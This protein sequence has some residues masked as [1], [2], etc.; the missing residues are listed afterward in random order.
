MNGTHDV[1]TIEQGAFIA[2]QV[3]DFTNNKIL[4]NRFLEEVSNS[5][6]FLGQN[7]VQDNLAL[8]QIIVKAGLYLLQ[9]GPSILQEHE[10]LF[11]G[12]LSAICTIIAG[13]PEILTLH[14]KPGAIAGEDELWSWL[15]N[16]LIN[17]LVTHEAENMSSSV[18]KAMYSVMNGLQL[19]NKNFD[20]VSDAI[21]FLLEIQEEFRLNRHV[22]KVT[23]KVECK[24]DDCHA[25]VQVRILLSIARFAALSD[26][27]ECLSLASRVRNEIAIRLIELTSRGSVP[28]L[29]TDSSV[30]F[31]LALTECTHVLGYGTLLTNWLPLVK[32]CFEALVEITQ[33]PD[34]NLTLLPN[35]TANG[36]EVAQRKALIMCLNDLASLLLQ[37]SERG[38]FYNKDNPRAVFSILLPIIDMLPASLQFKAVSLGWSD[39]VMQNSTDLAPGKSIAPI[40]R[41]KSG[42]HPITNPVLSRLVA[43]LSLDSQPLDI[44]NV[45]GRIV[46]DFNGF[47]SDQQI[48]AVQ[49]FGWIAC[50]TRSHLRSTPDG[51]FSCF[52]CDKASSGS[53]FPL[54]SH[55]VDLLEASCAAV[56]RLETTKDNLALRIELMRTFCRISKHAIVAPDRDINKSPTIKFLHSCLG[57]MSRHVRMLTG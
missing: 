11:A 6:A 54:I 40:F 26:R 29:G 16:H 56:T 31:L 37:V 20:A 46:Q 3:A 13:T 52:L 41:K 25:L 32:S 21:S 34:R 19:Q 12:S 22:N 42:E 27:L 30:A 10:A 4:F 45:L 53:T 36:M 57:D 28:H 44:P 35:V 49:C 38:A 5:K 15:L 39:S 18:C 14:V 9:D 7:S 33:S 55:P 24:S 23:G 51:S 43:A 17:L 47:S 1:A 8:V 50:A 48:Y 2:S